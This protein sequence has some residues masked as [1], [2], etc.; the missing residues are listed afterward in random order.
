MKTRSNSFREQGSVLVMAVL[1]MAILSA[2]CATSLY[3]ASQ[4]AN[5]GAQAASW[6]Q[7]LSAA[8]S[9]V[10]QAIAALNTGTWTGW[11][12]FDGPV[13]NLQPTPSPSPTPPPAAT[14]PPPNLKYNYISGSVTPQ[15]AQYNVA[16]SI[17]STS[18]G[19]P[20]VAMWTTID[21]ASL[22]VDSNG[23]QWYRIRATG[24]AA[25]V[26]PSR[27]SNQSL[28]NDLR[29]IGLRF[30]RK[31]SNAIVSPQASRT[32]EVIVQAL[33]QSMWVRAITLKG[34]IT[35]SGGGSFVDSFN[36]SNPFKSNNGLYDVN[37]R[38]SHGDIATASSG[39]NSNLNNDYVYGN[40]AYSGPAVKN[41]TD[42][43]G[44]ISTPFNTTIPDT[45]DPASDGSGGYTWTNPNPQGGQ[46]LSY[47]WPT[48]TYTKYTGGGS[49]PTTTPANT[50]TAT[51]T[52][53]N[54][55][56][57]KVVNTTNGTSTDFTVSGGNTFNIVNGNP[58]PPGGTQPPAYVT[59]WVTGKF[60]ESGGSVVTQAS[61]VNVTW[62]VDSDISISGGSYSNQSGYAANT[63]FIGVGTS[64]TFTDSGNSNFIGTVNAPG[65]SATVSGGGYYGGSLIANKLTI[66]GGSSFH[67]DE[68]LNTNSA[69]SAVGNYAF[70]SWFE[71]TR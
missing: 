11:R 19:N 71:D 49:P 39:T 45:K 8:E 68:A 21:T 48:G 36:S 26:G 61:N 34:A 38:Q 32:I 16:G 30:D 41:T 35:I 13:P 40:L 64:N 28:D 2:I 43:Q 6:Q 66:S 27:V 53:T 15:S 54:P 4:N 23:G 55:N 7:S 31:T 12:S 69:S 42:V 57:I 37:K 62:I 5:S 44:T 52:Q 47:S 22:P 14:G 10:D 58:T 56:L 63:S 67:F 50:F 51:G 60:V 24:T 29:K 46:T 65:Y 33:P 59:V 25:A 17:T 1:T 9:G 3:I 70:A 18:E 20:L